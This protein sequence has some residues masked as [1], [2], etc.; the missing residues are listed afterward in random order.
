M[1]ADELGSFDLVTL[2]KVLE[3]VRG[4]ITMLKRAHTLLR[5]G[6]TV[7]VEVPDGERAAADGPG[8]EEFFVEHVCAFSEASLGLALERAGLVERRVESVRDPSGKYTLV[9]FAA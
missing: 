9:A 3:H 1:A 5:E 7:Y 8:R 6:G 2:N 4:P